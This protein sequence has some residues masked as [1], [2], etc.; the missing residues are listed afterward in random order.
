[1]QPSL[2]L[3]T[4]VLQVIAAEDIS[5]KDIDLGGHSHFTF[6]R[7]EDICDV[8]LVGGWHLSLGALLVLLGNRNTPS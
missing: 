7:L 8:C 1:M 6:G 3:I 5:N 2:C 4:L